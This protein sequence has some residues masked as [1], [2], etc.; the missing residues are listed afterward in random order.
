MPAFRFTARDPEGR[1]QNGTLDA[2]SRRDAIRVLTARKL[3]PVLVEEVS[4]KGGAKTG[5]PESSKRR[6]TRTVG[7]AG[8][9]PAATPYSGRHQLPFLA[10]LSEL[11]TAGIPVGDAIRILGARLQ[12][13]ALRSLAGDLWS[14]ISEGSS[15]ARAMRDMPQVFQ[16][17]S[18]N[19]VEAG[20]ATGNL[21]E[22]LPRLTE[23]YERIAEVRSKLA[24]AAA[25]PLFILMLAAGVVLFF[26]YFL[27]PRMQSLFE[28][29]RGEIPWSTRLLI[30]A[31]SWGLTWGPVLLVSLVIAAALFWQWRRTPAGRL[32]TDTFLLR[33]PVA[34]DFI[35]GADMLQ[36][37]QTLAVLLGNGITMIEALR[38]AEGNV[39]NHALRSVFSDTRVRVAEGSSVTASLGLSPHI[40][41]MDLDLL[42]IGEQTGNLVPSLRNIATAYQRRQTRQIQTFLG[43][44]SNAVLISAF[45][46][47]GFIAYAIV[48]AVF[49]LSASF[50]GR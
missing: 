19:L 9:K 42:A 15:V 35:V 31:S 14:R 26:L 37:T 7:V 21:K 43:V 48:S 8:K 32:K 50:G 38:L 13:P 17:M 2:A 29:L 12:E 49:G 41:R 10:A 1:S 6:E 25:Y 18:V 16:E 4:A 20:E 24:S 23:H 22:I 39:S 34:R 33:V 47:V 11:I 36:A 30:Q 3:T 45:L 28:A 46:V 44:F 5:A 40:P 27:L